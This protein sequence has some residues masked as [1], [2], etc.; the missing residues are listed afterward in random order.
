MG[1]SM[2][3][4]PLQFEAMMPTVKTIFDT[5]KKTGD[6]A[7][8]EYT[9]KF[10][11]VDCTSFQI[12]AETISEAKAKI[13]EPLRK[14]IGQA[15]SNITAFHSAQRTNP[16]RGNTTRSTMLARKASYREGRALYSWRLSTLIFNCIDVS[17]PR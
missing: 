15:H 10:D 9:L 5:V 14:A 1:S 17:H 13:P 11:Q 8:K 4:L 12:P 6:Q 2:F 16:I 7:L 3:V